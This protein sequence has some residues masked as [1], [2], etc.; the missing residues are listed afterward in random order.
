MIHRKENNFSTAVFLL[1]IIMMFFNFVS[2][3]EEDTNNVSN[4][5]QQIR[6]D[7]KTLEKAVYKTSQISNT[8]SSTKCLLSFFDIKIGSGTPQTLCLE[9]HQS[10]LVSIIDFILSLPLLG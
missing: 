9:T 10:G 5:I 1:L 8:S 6:K 3:E 7:I 4:E 2:A